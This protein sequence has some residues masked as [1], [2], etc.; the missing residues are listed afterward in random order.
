MAIVLQLLQ[1]IVVS[2]YINQS[3]SRSTWQAEKK[4]YQELKR[5]GIDSY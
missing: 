1:D 2:L 3:T 4:P 5:V